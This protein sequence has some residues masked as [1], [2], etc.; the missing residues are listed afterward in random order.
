M[1]T[2][3]ALH[4]DKVMMYTIVTH[5]LTYYTIPLHGSDIN[6]QMRSGLTMVIK[7]DINIRMAVS[8]TSAV[9]QI[10]DWV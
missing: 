7:A 2:T 9:V 6:L 8:A 1:Y 4:E 5:S 10:T 3:L